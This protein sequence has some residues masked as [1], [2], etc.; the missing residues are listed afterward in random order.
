L[1]NENELEVQAFLAERALHNAVMIGLIRDNG[2]ESNFNRGTFY[3]CRDVAEGLVGVALI[4]HAVF[5]DARGEDAPREFARL[6]QEIPNVHMLM[7]D[8]RMVETFWTY[9]AQ[10][11]QPRRRICRE[12]LFEL[13]D[14][15]T[16]Y[17]DSTDLRLA[18]V[19]DLPHVVPVHATMAFEESGVN[20]LVVDPDGFRQRCRRRIADR[21]TWVLIENDKLIFKADVVSDTAEVIYLEG[22]YVHPEYRGQGHGTRCLTQLTR[23]LLNQTRSI[24]LLVNQE[25]RQALEFF[26]KLGFVSRGLYDTVFLWA[27]PEMQ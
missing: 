18:E 19:N 15:S 20:P 6:A 23:G 14:Q 26:R 11:G 12:V 25:R 27:Q 8:H 24:S 17:D 3:G 5:I 16:T 22:V 21:R 9:Y 13:N 4:G 2:V 10:D 7:G 1:R